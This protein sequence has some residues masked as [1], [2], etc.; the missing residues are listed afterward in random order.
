MTLFSICPK[1][2]QCYLSTKSALT[3][4]GGA[5]SIIQVGSDSIL[6]CS[7]IYKFV[8]TNTFN[9]HNTIAYIFYLSLGKWMEL[10]SVLKIAHST[11]N[12]HKKM[13]IFFFCR[14][15]LKKP[16]PNGNLLGPNFGSLILTLA[17]PSH[18]PSTFCQR[19]NQFSD[20]LDA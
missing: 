9:C 15:S 7:V 6:L 14:S 8:T 13:K 3:F 19:Q 16:T 4:L 10:K 18:P 5:N 11:Q 17:Q 20:S 1:G 2:A 12:F